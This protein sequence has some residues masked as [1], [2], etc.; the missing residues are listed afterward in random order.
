MS[1]VLL[2]NMTCNS[3]F[4][5]FEGLKCVR[6]GEIFQEGSMLLCVKCG[7]VNIVTSENSTRLMTKAE[8]EDMS[9]NCPED[10]NDLYFAIRV[11]VQNHKQ[12]NKKLIIP[13][14]YHE[15]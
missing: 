2:T 11:L 6:P 14:W 10:K 1:G 12:Q 9:K 8:W 5:P 4:H 15:R 3:C 7:L 13:S